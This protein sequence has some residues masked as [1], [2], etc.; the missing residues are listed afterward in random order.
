[1]CLPENQMKY[2]IA[3]FINKLQQELS[4]N[5]PTRTLIE[6]ISDL[7]RR[8]QNLGRKT[9]KHFWVQK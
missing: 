3:S 9:L 4:C 8:G 7:L 5:L 1:M 6:I 2:K